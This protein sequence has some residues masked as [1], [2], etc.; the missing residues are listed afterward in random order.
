[1]NEIQSKKNT[2]IKETKK[3]S[4]KKYRQQNQQ[5]LID[6]WHLVQEAIKAKAD[7][8]TIFVTPH[9]YEEYRERL[10]TVNAAIYLITD[11][12]AAYLSELPTPQ[13]IFAVVAKNDQL[14]KQLKGNW[15]ILDNVQDPGNVGTMIRTAD[16]AGFAGVFLGTGTAD[17]YSTKVLRS[18]Q[19]SNFHLPIVEGAIP[20][21]IAALRA[22]EVM[23][24]GT[25]LN[26]DA[27]AYTDIKHYPAA[28]ILGN[29]GQGVQKELLALTDHNVYIPI[30]GEAESLNVAIAAG[31]LMYHAA[32]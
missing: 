3:L 4:Q 24:Y 6:G 2:L 12:I 14:P 17:L 22:E 29:E 1:M 7:I 10:D 13:G 23:I 16:A 28:F 30:Y 9:G 31:I 8:Q 19:G 20:D 18:M 5:Y 15:L 25:E 27:L 32:R 11:E 21:F 26:K